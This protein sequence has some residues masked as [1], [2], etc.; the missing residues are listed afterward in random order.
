[1][2]TEIYFTH[3]CNYGENV[4]MKKNKEREK[5]RQLFRIIYLVCVKSFMYIQRL[6]IESCQI[7][8]WF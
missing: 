2:A 3:S 8:K 6:L 1:M 7:W 5:E 4:F